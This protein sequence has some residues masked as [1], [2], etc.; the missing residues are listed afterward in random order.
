VCNGICRLLYSLLLLLRVFYSYYWFPCQ[1]CICRVLQLV[2]SL[3]KT[4][5]HIKTSIRSSSYTNHISF[6]SPPS[7]TLI[8]LNSLLHQYSFISILRWSSSFYSIHSCIFIYSQPS[9]LHV[10]HLP[11]YCGPW[12]CTLLHRRV[13]MSGNWSESEAGSLQLITLTFIRALA[14]LTMFW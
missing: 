7:I 10:Y 11:P 4:F 2:F 14:H 9:H 13:R 1:M 3:V 5:D 8:T 12:D 6:Y